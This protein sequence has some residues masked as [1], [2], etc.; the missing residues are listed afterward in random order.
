MYIYIYFFFHLL[1]TETKVQM[2]FS[3]L[4]GCCW[5]IARAFSAY[6]FTTVFTQNA[7]SFYLENTFV[8]LFSRTESYETQVAFKNVAA[9]C[10]F[11][12][13]HFPLFI[14]CFT[15]AFL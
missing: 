7:F 4:F 3:A 6:S 5:V 12:K 1:G 11:R 9:K 14:R 2:R 10:A 13:T 8:C 15:E